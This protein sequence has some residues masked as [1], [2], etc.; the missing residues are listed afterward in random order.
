MKIG[1]KDIALPQCSILI[2]F[3]KMPFNSCMKQIRTILKYEKFKE[4]LL[5]IDLYRRRVTRFLL[6]AWLACLYKYSVLWSVVYKSNFWLRRNKT[7]CRW[8][9]NNYHWL[10]PYNVCFLHDRKFSERFSFNYRHDLDI[11]VVQYPAAKAFLMFVI[12]YVPDKNSFYLWSPTCTLKPAKCTRAEGAFKDY[13]KCL[14]ILIEKCLQTGKVRSEK[15][16]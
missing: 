4:I 1:G 8:A 5:S 9:P 2:L 12:F 16:I 15:L 14:L 6:F 7:V 10:L 3:F 13:T 11:P